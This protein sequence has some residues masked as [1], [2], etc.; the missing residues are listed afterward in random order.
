MVHRNFDFRWMFEKCMLDRCSINVR[1]VFDILFHRCSIYVLTARFQVQGSGRHGSHG[2]VSSSRFSRIGFKF[3][4]QAVTVRTVR[5]Q[6]QGSHGSVS[7]SRHM[8]FARFA[9]HGSVSSLRF[10]CTARLQVQGSRFARFGFK[11]IWQERSRIAAE[12]ASYFRVG[13]RIAA[14][15]ASYDRRRGRL[16][17]ESASYCRKCCRIAA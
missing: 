7:S 3:Q 15:S 16:A 14:Q 6:V 17:A 10:A 2:S 12:S 5:F 8:P 9:L 13:S 11:F 1:Y 4:A